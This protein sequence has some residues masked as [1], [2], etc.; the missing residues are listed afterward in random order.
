MATAHHHHHKKDKKKRKKPNTGRYPDEVEHKLTV[1]TGY[2]G[3]LISRENDVL[4]EL[5]RQLPP[6]DYHHL[7]IPGELDDTFSDF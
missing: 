6:A 1:E 4:Q 5:K 3:Q 7:L 2:Y